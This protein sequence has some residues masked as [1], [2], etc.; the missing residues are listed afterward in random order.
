MSVSSVRRPLAVVSAALFLCACKGNSGPPSLPGPPIADLQGGSALVPV[1]HRSNTKIEHIVIVVQENR[2]FNDLFHGFPGA[3]TATYGYGIN[4]EKIE[5]K[6]IPLETTWNLE[7]NARGFL[8]ACNG[9]GKIP[10][11]HCRMNGFDRETWTCGGAQP[12]CPQKNPP[13]SYVPHRETKP[14]FEIAKQY[15]LGDE[16]FA[17]NFD[18][19]S[20]ISH[21]YIIAAQNPDSSV[22]YPFGAWGCPGGK[23]DR[24]AIL[25]AQR[26]F[27][28]GY[29]VPCWNTRTLGDELNHAGLSWAFYAVSLVDGHGVWSAYQA[30]KHVYYGRDWSKDV[31]SPPAAFLTDVSNGHLRTVSWVTPTFKDSDHGG[32]GSNTGPSWVASVVNAIGESQYWRSTVIFIFWD[33]YGGWYDPVAPAYVDN[34]GLGARLPLLIVSPYAKKGYV[35]HVHYEHGSILKFIEDQF[36]LGRLAASDTRARSPER[37]CFDF[38]RPPRKFVPIPAP[39]DANYF[40]DEPGDQRVP[41]TE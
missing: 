28:H 25:G 26:E 37:D 24:I 36:G 27:P 21:Q 41:D 17:S 14:Y 23:S 6:P 20:F 1:V 10:G 22:D 32:S 13:Y 30:I 35:S 31:I 4:D 38:A 2:S 7:H 8:A 29:A 39:H 12:A 9:T 33:D 18:S 11:T 5:L 19:S 40:K 3:K 16:M 15:V 34:D